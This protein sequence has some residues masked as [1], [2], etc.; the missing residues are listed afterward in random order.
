MQKILNVNELKVHSRKEI[1]E[2]VKF[3]GY[4]FEELKNGLFFIKILRKLI[5]SDI[6]KHKVYEK[7][8]NIY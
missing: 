2:W 1:M 6:S 7:A 3:H 5:P 8:I 4:V